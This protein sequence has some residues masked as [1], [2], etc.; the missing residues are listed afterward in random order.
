MTRV[1]TAGQTQ[2]LLNTLLRHQELQQQHQLEVATLK[3]STDFKSIAREAV[4]LLGA[5]EVE[6]RIEQFLKS[7]SLI[8]QRLE[9]YN[10]SLQR[11]VDI[12]LTLRADLITA[13]D[14]NSAVAFMDKVEAG[15]SEAA[16]VVN[17]RFNGQYI[18]AGTR[19]QTPPVNAT[20]AAA[21]LA[22]AQTA[23]AFDNNAIK[24]EARISDNT[25]REYGVLAEDVAS[26]LFDGFR[27]L[28]EFNAG[29]LP[30]GAGAFAP[31]GAF[32]SPLTDNQREFLVAEL[33]GIQAAIDQLNLEVAE[34]GVNMQFLE[35]IQERHRD[36]ITFARTLIAEIENVDPAEAITKLNESAQALEASIQVLARLNRLSLLN[37]I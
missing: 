35:Q 29:T 32:E 17:T 25:V 10:V 21:L 16:D 3:K 5:R 28:M 34:N 20:T 36:D 11:L 8:E 30:A 2:L 1:S 12:A 13:I 37:F 24:A 27:R 6:V 19:T 18:F 9:V 31:A 33:V 23:D 15:F 4:P 7:N 14:S 22:L 26:S